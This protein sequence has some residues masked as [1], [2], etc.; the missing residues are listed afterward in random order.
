MTIDT[1]V[2][3]LR[4]CNSANIS[5]CLSCP[6]EVGRGDCKS[7]YDIAADI[8]E[9]QQRQIEDMKQGM[10]Q[11]AKAVAVKDALD[12]ASKHGV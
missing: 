11:L 3:A 7:L 8:I 6:V 12:T 2:N 4:C 5:A 10:E 1:I 9:K